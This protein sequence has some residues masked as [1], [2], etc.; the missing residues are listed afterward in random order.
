MAQFIKIPKTCSIIEDGNISLLVQNDFKEKLLKQGILDPEKLMESTPFP[1]KNSFK[2]RGSVSSILIQDSNN[3][4]MVAKRC[5]RGG[6]LRFLNRD[7]FWGGNRP[8]NEMIANTTIMEKGILTSE[9]IAAVKHK[10]FGPVYRAYL[11]SKEIPECIDLISF[12]DGL[13]Q[14]SSEQRLKAKRYLFRAIAAAF[15]KMHKEGIYHSDLHIKNVL[16]KHKD[17]SE[18]EIYIIDFDKTDIKENLTPKQKVKNLL[19]FNRSIEKYR[20][21]GGV[22]TRT[23]QLRMLKEYFKLDLDSLNIYSI[24]KKRYIALLKL[25][26]W[27]WRFFNVASNL[28]KS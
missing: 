8:F 14:K 1:S 21:K 15:I 4:R 26:I 20:L 10:L 5:L 2:G 11:F 18:P 6:L 17:D 3:E 9:I 22:V 25:R 13:K 24:N 12:F 27:K 19:R 23:D 28:L 7:T 16:V